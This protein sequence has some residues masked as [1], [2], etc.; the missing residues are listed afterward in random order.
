MPIIIGDSGSDATAGDDGLQDPSI[1]LNGLTLTM[2][3]P[4]PADG[5]LIEVL[6]DDLEPGDPEAVIA[7]IQSQLQDGD[8]ERIDRFGNR[9]ASIPLQ[10]S[11][12]DHPRPGAAIAA[13]Q[14]ALELAC[15]FEGFA[16]LAWTSCLSGAETSIAEM[17]TAVVA[18][19]AND[20]EEA[21]NL[22]R[23]FTVTVH[24]RPFVRPADPI[25]FEAAPV[26]G[27]TTSVVDDGSSK[28]GWQMLSTA[29]EPMHNPIT[30]PSF[31]SNTTGWAAASAGGTSAISRDT[32]AWSGKIGS[33]VLYNDGPSVAGGTNAN[34]YAQSPAVAV[35]PGSKQCVLY[36][37][38]NGSNILS[39]SVTGRTII[40]FYSDAAGTAQ[41]GTDVLKT[42]GDSLNVFTQRA[43]IVDVPAGAQT[44]RVFPGASGKNTTPPADGTSFNLDDRVDAVG[45]IEVTEDNPSP[46]YFD[47]TTTDTPAITYTADTPATPNNSA[48][49]A[50][51]TAPTLAVSSGSVKGT[52]YGRASASIRRTAAV[53]MSSLNYMR[54]RGTA[55]AYSDGQVTVADNGGAPI[56]PVTSSYSPTS[57]A[58]DILL[59]R[60]GGFAAVDVTFARTGGAISTT[61]GLFVAVDSIEITDNPVGT[62]RVQVRQ[63]PIDGSQRTELSISVLGLSA[64]GTTPQDLGE[65]VLVHSSSVLDDQR[66]KFVQCRT[67][68]GDTGTPDTTAVS[69]FYDVL[70]V[71]GTPTVFTI[72]A[73]E[74][75]PGSWLVIPRLKPIT[76]GSKTISYA[77][78]VHSG[79]VGV[80]DP[81]SGWST[82]PLAVDTPWPGVPLN[83]WR[84]LP[85]GMLRLPP[86]D[87]EDPTATIDIKLAASAANAVQVDEVFLV[88]ATSGELTLLN[89][90]AGVSAVRLDAASTDRAQPS[91][92]VGVAN[93]PMVQVLDQDFS[94]HQ[95]VPQ[96]LSVSIVAPSCPTTRLSGH[97]PPRYAHDVAARKSTMKAALAGSGA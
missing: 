93:G 14:L 11:A 37:Q 73:A 21:V 13:G 7:S 33:A 43:W 48:S 2:T 36:R 40:R 68:S 41:V 30:N 77:A 28:T 12:P 47:A 69:G 91:A 88:H 81:V 84:M 83:A 5:Y 10:I 42:Y 38:M 63:I 53:D 23:Y 65:Q 20:L 50:T 70:G 92:W 97:Y 57:G 78:T 87:I 67:S 52:A 25:T 24:A 34:I 27:S 6:G 64:D 51:W 96:L 80:S 15:R 54:I 74:L 95:A 66:S 59:Y 29:P 55:S 9:E 72:N 26:I 82:C 58:F 31:E 86:A 45:I 79:S 62:G 18:K 46:W 89:L 19:D 49:T 39:F 8:P 71:V 35:A 90:S 56:T 16:E 61:S 94:Q 44:M 17:S 85:L 4:D 76:S 22:V 1:V 60:P 3:E 32:S 75:L